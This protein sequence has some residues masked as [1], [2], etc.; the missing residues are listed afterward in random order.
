MAFLIIFGLGLMLTVVTLVIGELFDFGGDATADTGSE[1]GEGG[2]SPL[3]SRIVFVFATAFGGFGFI[4]REFGWEIWAQLLA[5]MAGGV[6]VAGGTFF[7]IVVPMAKQQ[8]TVRVR[9]SD[10]ID[11]EGQVTAEIPENGL[12]RVTLVA[13]SSGARVAQAARSANGQ[14]IPYGAAV[15]V[16]Q[17]GQGTV[18]VVPAQSGLAPYSASAKEQQS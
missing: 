7:L 3:S 16:I 4:A 17:S 8:S 11:L 18:T 15:R 10:F 14:R 9:D 2:P 12:G 6:A 1:L 13:P 5:A